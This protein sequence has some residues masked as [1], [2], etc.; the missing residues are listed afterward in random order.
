MT[1]EARV[2]RPSALDAAERAAWVAFMRQSRPLC[3]AFLAPGFALAAEQAHGRAWVSVLREDGRIA[4]FFPFQFASRWHR[5]I[6]L[7]DRIGGRLSDNS[8]LV[9]RPGLRIEAGELLRLSGLGALFMTHLAEGQEAFGLVAEE[10][11]I[12]HEI[13]LG[14]GSAAY[15]SAL[16]TRNKS[17]V[18]DT[19]RLIRRLETKIA[20]PAFTYSTRPE[21]TDV[22]ATIALKREQYGKTGADD[23]FNDPD[24]LALCRALLQVGSPEMACVLSRTAIGNDVIA[25][26]FGLYCLGTLSYWFPVYDPRFAEFSP[27]R[28]D[29]WRTI[30]MAE[31]ETISLIDLGEGDSRAKRDFSN[32]M[33][34]LGVAMWR[35]QNFRSPLARGWQAVEWR[36]R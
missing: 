21:E 19:N 35:A 18:Q 23:P 2:K 20:A 4:G 32:H 5:L 22:L 30:E 29:L 28:I 31:A 12:G 36:L 17:F 11:R 1:L 10:T 15:F 25:Q 13:H 14:E 7:A 34:P 8:G 6:G 3:R 26:H 16:R 9:G 33:V 24:S 27:G